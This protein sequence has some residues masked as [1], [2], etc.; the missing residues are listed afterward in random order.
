M[1]FADTLSDGQRR[2]YRWTA[3]M[4]AWFGCVSEQLLD[5]NSLI[6]IYLIALGGNES[7]SMFSTALSTIFGMCLVIPC[8]GLASKIGL[9]A[10]Y[11]MSCIVSML[12]FLT[13]A[14][15]PSIVPAAYAKYLVMIGCAIYCMMRFPYSVSW[16]PILDMFLKPE[17]RG[18]FFGTMRFSYMLIN[19]AI[20]YGIGKLLG[21]NPSIEIM[22]IVIAVAGVLVLGRKFCMDRLPDNPEV[23]KNK[24]DIGKALNISIRNAPL[25]GFS[26]YSCFFNIAVSSA[27]PLAVIYMK[28]TLN[29]SA[30]T[31]MTLTSIY[32]VGL[33]SGFA[34]VGVSMRKLGARYFQIIMHTLHIIA[35]G[36]LCFILPQTPYAA[37]CMGVVM[38]ILG[39]AQS[40]CLCLNSTEMMASAKPGNKIMAMAFCLTFSNIGTSI[41]RT[42]TT[43]VLA[44]GV[45]APEWQ[46]FGKSMSCYNFMFMFCFVLTV[47]FYIFLILSPSIISKHDDY[48][49]S[50]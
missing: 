4:S 23:R 9:R 25:V 30:E 46:F 26:F 8:A 42:G 33:I 27:M 37:V 32:L 7:F 36:W 16:Y 48:Y 3:I 14:A 45:L 11:G 28:T 17:E 24:I 15:A 6:I 29:F 1:G 18:S 50:R 2:K 5:S 41:G 10:S 21:K 34:L 49:E 44:A 12:A 19:A 47:F 40:F 22:Q 20:I 39:F 38:F 13:M 35:I 43:L 31:I